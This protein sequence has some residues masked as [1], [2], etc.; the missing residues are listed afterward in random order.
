MDRRS[1]KFSVRED[2]QVQAVHSKKKKNSSFLSGFAFFLWNSSWCRIYGGK[3]RLERKIIRPLDGSSGFPGEET[4]I[5]REAMETFFPLWWSQLICEKGW[6]LMESTTLIFALKV[7]K[8]SFFCVILLNISSYQFFES[9]CG[10]LIIMSHHGIYILFTGE[11]LCRQ[12]GNDT[13]TWDSLSDG[14]S[15]RGKVGKRCFDFCLC[16]RRRRALIP[17]LRL[18]P[19]YHP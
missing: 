3:Y 6:N 16:Q 18:L 10:K 13:N 5:W 12:W 9:W 8:K 1:T 19:W 4:D 17:I 7:E 14:V 2:M 11:S 15:R